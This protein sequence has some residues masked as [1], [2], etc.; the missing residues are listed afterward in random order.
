M[1]FDAER[2]HR[3]LAETAEQLHELRRRLESHGPGQV[4]N[5]EIR[6]QI[7]LIL[8]DYT[9]NSLAPTG[10]WPSPGSTTTTPATLATAP[11]QTTPLSCPRCG[12]TVNVETQ[13][14]LELK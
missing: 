14:T 11:R 10:G 9:L 2:I 3:V 7:A 1:T 4:P 5:D 8:T 6:R 12:Q 13:L